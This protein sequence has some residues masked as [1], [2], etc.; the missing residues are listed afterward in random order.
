MADLAKKRNE[1]R[2]NALVR[3]G[4]CP[5]MFE[6]GT[7]A[8]MLLA[9]AGDVESVNFLITKFKANPE[10]ALEG[11]AR[12]GHT[13]QIE[14]LLQ[15]GRSLQY[16]F[17]G[18]AYG[19]HVDLIEAEKTKIANTI[20]GDSFAEDIAYGFALKG[21]ETQ[22]AKCLSE[23][24]THAVLAMAKQGYALGRHTA[25]LQQVQIE[26]D[27]ELESQLLYCYA[28]GGHSEIVNEIT[29]S[30][31]VDEKAILGY[32]AGGHFHADRHFYYCQI[33]L[34]YQIRTYGFLSRYK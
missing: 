34:L 11:Y 2:L 3:Q 19:G 13:A 26:E 22:V 18:L 17:R 33:H 1:D 14:K 8:I 15:E 16:V 23:T 25:L 21:D 24:N 30:F 27:S 9:E 20:F 7:N 28:K 4:I 29:D 31:E 12:G 6:A 32:G 10:H 5:G